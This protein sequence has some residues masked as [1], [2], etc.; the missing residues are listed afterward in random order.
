MWCRGR[1]H[2]GVEVGRSCSA[3]ESR[4]DDGSSAP[5]GGGRKSVNGAEIESRAPSSP[6][7][8]F[9]LVTVAWCV[10]ERRG[11]ARSSKIVFLEE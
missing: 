3:G 8:A 4:G 10:W 9:L 7:T 5:G 11:E 2:V 1:R 6:A